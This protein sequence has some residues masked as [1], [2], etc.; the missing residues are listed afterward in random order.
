LVI[1][2]VVLFWRV[3][4]RSRVFRGA[5]R[6]HIFTVAAEPGDDVGLPDLVEQR[7]RADVP[8]TARLPL[9]GADK[10]SI[11]LA[12]VF[13][14]GLGGVTAVVSDQPAVVVARRLRDRIATGDPGTAT[15]SR[16][17]RR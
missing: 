2:S 9:S 7:R 1:G 4:K 5:R 8:R 14:T 12:D 17:K 15:C 13:E 16:P 6:A 11:E 3:S 10:P